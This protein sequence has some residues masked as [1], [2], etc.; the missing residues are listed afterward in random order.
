[1]YVLTTARLDAAEHRWIAALSAYDFDIFYRPGKQNQDADAL[2]RRP[3]TNDDFQSICRDLIKAVCQAVHPSPL[4]TSFSLD[5]T[6]LDDNMPAQKV[7]DQDID[8]QHE[9]SSDQTLKVWIHYVR[10]KGKT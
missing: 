1:M 2:S 3:N 6:V 10:R 8:C 4:I 9:Q 5:T 7:I